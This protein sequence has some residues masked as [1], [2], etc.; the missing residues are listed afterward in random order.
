MFKNEFRA[1]LGKYQGCFGI[2]AFGPS[3]L[4]LHT[5][6]AK[7]NVILAWQKPREPAARFKRPKED[8]PECRLSVPL[9]S[10]GNTHIGNHCMFLTLLTKTREEHRV[11]KHVSFMHPDVIDTMGSKCSITDLKSVNMYLAFLDWC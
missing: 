8:L 3:R 1:S 5:S 9:V 4:V 2:P 7:A 6:A 11:S 10:R